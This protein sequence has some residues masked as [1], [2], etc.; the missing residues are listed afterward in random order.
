MHLNHEKK[1]KRL[2][3]PTP[4]RSLSQHSPRDTLGVYMEEYS[5]GASVQ[6]RRQ[7]LMGWCEIERRLHLVELP[8]CGSLVAHGQTNVSAI[9][10]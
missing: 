1:K 2:S 3:C 9:G 5:S 6:F 4:D 10:D 8:E 7:L